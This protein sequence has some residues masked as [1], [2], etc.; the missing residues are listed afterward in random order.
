MTTSSATARDYRK[1]YQILKSGEL[2]DVKMVRASW[3]GGGP[4]V[5]EGHNASEEKVRNW[6]FYRELSGDIL[7]EQDCHNID[8]VNWFTGSHPVKVSGY[9][10]RAIRLYGDVFDNLACTF[11]FANGND[12]QLRGE[13]VRQFRLSGG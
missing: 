6:F 13:S 8:V 7:V 2:G 10:G 3:F 9:G 12:L 5:K 11:E 4:A 1:A